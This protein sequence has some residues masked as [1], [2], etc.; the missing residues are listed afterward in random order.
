M[1]KRTLKK[2][3]MD[4]RI[5]IALVVFLL[6]L[7]LYSQKNEKKYLDDVIF[8]SKLFTLSK[9]LEFKKLSF[10]KEID[11]INYTVNETEEFVFVKIKNKY[12]CENEES[13]YSA[14]WCYGD[15]Y[16]CFSKNKQR[17]YL[18]GGFI[19]NDVKEFSQ[20]Y[21]KSFLFVNINYQTPDSKLNLFLECLKKNKIKKAIKVFDVYIEN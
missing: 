9:H 8:N 3:R 13:N 18:L 19:K 5:V 11:R 15:Y 12:F 20:E 2:K 7:S 17:Y 16:V 1:E 21:K 4:N 6:S 14:L 10:Y